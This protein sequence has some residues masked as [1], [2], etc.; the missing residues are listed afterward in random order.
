MSLLLPTSNQH[1]EW[2]L[3]L[4]C[5][6]SPCYDDRDFLASSCLDYVLVYRH[7]FS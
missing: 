3:E 7:V 5:E 6:G 4:A 2:L 1:K